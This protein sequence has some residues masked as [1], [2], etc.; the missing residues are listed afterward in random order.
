LLSKA[1]KPIIFTKETIANASKDRKANSY[2]K[3]QPYKTDRFET[4][5][6]V[7]ITAPHDTIVWIV[8]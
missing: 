4:S 2:F 5:A 6:K 3:Q 7:E 1:E 8:G